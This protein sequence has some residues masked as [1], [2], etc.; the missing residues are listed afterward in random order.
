ML[1]TTI[2]YTLALGLLA[3]VPLWLLGAE[4][5]LAYMWV[6]LIG[7][8][9]GNM[10][11]T[12]VYRLPRGLS[13]YGGPKGEPP[14][15]YSCKTRLGALDLIPVLTW[16]LLKG[17]CR[18]CGAPFPGI[19]AAVEFFVGAAFLASFYLFGMSFK[20]VASSLALACMVI[21]LAI[22]VDSKK[23]EWKPLTVAAAAFILAFAR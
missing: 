11:T 5:S 20:F 2:D 3:S 15:C 9:A 13:F 10:A 22:Y 8:S 18:Y 14:Y 1:R 16:L 6:A 21:T 12:V 7:F 17:K 4:T 19:Y 23:L